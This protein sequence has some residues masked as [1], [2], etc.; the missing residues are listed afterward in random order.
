MA[1]LEPDAEAAAMP[2]QPGEEEAGALGGAVPDATKE[3]IEQ[4][5]NAMDAKDVELKKQLTDFSSNN[6]E[7]AAQLIRSWLKGG[8][9][10]GG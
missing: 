3:S 1:K 7:I 4:A 8:D 9:K 2:L 10:H 5:R 6:P